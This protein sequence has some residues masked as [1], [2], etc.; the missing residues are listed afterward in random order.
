[1]TA[2]R[3]RVGAR[4]VAIAVVAAVA[5]GSV[6]V[7][8]HA[9]RRGASPSVARGNGLRA[10]PSVRVR[11]AQHSLRRLGYRLSADGRFGRRTERAV[12]RYQAR[13]GLKA[14]G[15]VGR[16]T[17][18]ALRR[19]VA[20]V[21]RIARR[22]RRRRA[23][24]RRERRPPARDARTARHP[25]TPSTAVVPPAAAPAAVLPDVPQAPTPAPGSA[26]AVE[27]G[28]GRP[29]QVLLTI[30]AVAAVLFIAAAPLLRE[31]LRWGPP[32]SGRRNARS[33]AAG[34]PRRRPRRV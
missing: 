8:G 28:S 25:R 4:F 6:P 1:M 16:S 9:A 23:H 3:N 31:P 14:D 24:A 34:G 7:M 30:A 13:H 18:R 19:S 26:R 21:E 5:L 11:A 27:A 33:G 22:A 17:R 15:V 2:Y 12:L 32:A 10:R 20:R 29:P